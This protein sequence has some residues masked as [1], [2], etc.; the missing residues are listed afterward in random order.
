MTT[1]RLLVDYVHPS[2]GREVG[3]V[4]SRVD[5]DVALGAGQVEGD[6]VDERRSPR[7][8][9]PT[10]SEPSTNKRYPTPTP[11]DCDRN[12]IDRLAV[13]RKPCYLKD[14]RAMRPIYIHRVSEKPYLRP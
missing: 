8:T 5:V 4:V 13:T 10:T 3:A 1:T 6:A 9:R 14:G 7:Q 12:T 2:R 11:S